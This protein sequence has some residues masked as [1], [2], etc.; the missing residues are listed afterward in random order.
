MSLTLPADNVLFS[1]SFFITYSPAAAACPALHLLLPSFPSLPPSTWL[2]L[3]ASLPLTYVVGLAWQCV[4]PS[5]SSVVFFVLRPASRSAGWSRRSLSLLFIPA[6]I[7]PSLLAPLALSLLFA[8]LCRRAVA[9]WFL[10][11][12]GTD[13]LRYSTYSRRSWVLPHLHS[14]LVLGCPGPTSSRQRQIKPDNRV[15]Q[16]SCPSAFCQCCCCWCRRCVWRSEVCWRPLLLRGVRTACTLHTTH[17]THS[18]HHTHNTRQH[19]TTYTHA[20]GSELDT[21]TSSFS[22]HHHTQPLGPS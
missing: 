13:R 16:L 7:R 21:Q 8:G 5:P 9:L 10:G 3:C 1:F 15:N 2:L 12:L 6:R 22:A 18:T 20:P 11:R 14:A 17:S 19:S 4:P